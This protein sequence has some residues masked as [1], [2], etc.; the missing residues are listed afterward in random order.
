MIFH[1]KNTGTTTAAI[2]VFPDGILADAGNAIWRFEGPQI[3][4]AGKCP[5]KK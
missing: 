3:S 2:G 5:P 1:I 4:Q